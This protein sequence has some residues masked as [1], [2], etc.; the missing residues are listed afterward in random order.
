[1]SVGCEKQKSLEV[2]F[3]SLVSPSESGR[4]IRATGCDKLILV[5]SYDES[6]VRKRLIFGPSWVDSVTSQENYFFFLLLLLNLKGKKG[7]N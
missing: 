6:L 2:V 7:R 3:G 5:S 1:M 4:T